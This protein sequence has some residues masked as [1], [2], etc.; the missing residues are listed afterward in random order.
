MTRGGYFPVLPARVL[1]D[2][3]WSELDLEAL[4]AW[5]RLSAYADL[6][7]EPVPMATAERFGVTG[8]I[9]S[10]LAD[11]GAAVLGEDG[12]EPVMM[13]PH[14]FPSDEP[15]A[16]LERVRRHRSREKEP[17]RDTYTSQARGRFVTSETTETT[18][19]N[20]TS[21]AACGQPASEGAPLVRRGGKPMHRFGCP[22]PDGD[23]GHVEQQ[24]EATRA[25]TRRLSGQ[26]DEAGSASEELEWPI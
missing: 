17:K 21:C 8:E 20:E 16:V 7:N 2:A 22:M 19:T 12:I 1:N 11:A 14:K 26:P 23:D 5:V 18:E 15:E 9:L 25:R 13:A 10:R 3:R 4:G 6:M 24:I